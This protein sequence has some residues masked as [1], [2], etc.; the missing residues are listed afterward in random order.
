[1]T[2]YYS[3]LFSVDL[4]SVLKR[5]ISVFGWYGLQMYCVSCVVFISLVLPDDV[6]L[7]LH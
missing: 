7:C 2:S 5:L 4:L 6:G 3:L 1:M